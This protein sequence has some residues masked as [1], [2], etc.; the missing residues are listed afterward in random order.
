MRTLV[1][2]I[3]LASHAIYLEKAQ[4]DPILLA[5]RNKALRELSKSLDNTS[6]RF[7]MQLDDGYDIYMRNR[8][9]LPKRQVD[10]LVHAYGIDRLV[11]AG[12][13]ATARVEFDA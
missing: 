5:A 12:L 7:G 10:A 9:R 13:V 1:G 11:A 8:K 4:L 3:N 6:L 2:E